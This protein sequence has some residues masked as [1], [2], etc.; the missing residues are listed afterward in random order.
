MPIRP[1]LTFHGLRHSHKTW[2]IDDGMPEIPQARR[3]GHHLSNRVVEAY[4]HV[5]ADLNQRLLEGL[6]RRWHIAHSEAQAERTAVP[7]Q[8]SKLTSDRAVA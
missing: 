5:A 8:V 3:L 2:L 6:E 1:G 4:S 7:E